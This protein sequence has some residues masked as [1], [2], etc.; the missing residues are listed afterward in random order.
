MYDVGN[1]GIIWK[2]CYMEELKIEV[3]SPW[4]SWELGIGEV[5]FKQGHDLA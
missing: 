1:T 5:C 4:R 2:W 3:V